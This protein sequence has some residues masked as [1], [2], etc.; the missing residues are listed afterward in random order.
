LKKNEAII[1]GKIIF[2]KSLAT[3]AWLATL[4][5][6]NENWALGG[7]GDKNRV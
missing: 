7:C 6:P 3:S 5:L 1:R 2:E 4:A